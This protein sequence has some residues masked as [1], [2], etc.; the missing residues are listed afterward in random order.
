MIDVVRSNL[1]PGDRWILSIMCRTLRGD[2]DWGT[3]RERKCEIKRK[4]ERKMIRKIVNT[5]KSRDISD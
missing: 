5:G 3:M 2:R 4:R 1:G